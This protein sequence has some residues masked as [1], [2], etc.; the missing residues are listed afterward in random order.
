[1]TATTV[2]RTSHIGELGRF[3]H[4]RLPDGTELYFDPSTHRYFGEVKENAKANGGYSYVQASSLVGCSTPSKQLDTDP[5]PLMGWAA[6]LDQTGVAQLAAAALEA[7]EPL[8][9]LCTQRGIAEALWQSELTWRHV[10]DRMAT[11]GT[12]IHERIFLALATGKRPPSLSALSSTERAYGQAAIKWWRA[13]DP[14][15]LFAEHLTAHPELRVAGRFDLLCEIGGE[16]VLVDAKTREKGQARR[17]D[18]V[19][20]A[21]YEL[22]NEA[23][24][25][26]TSDRQAILILKPDGTPVEKRSKAEPA[27]FLAALGAY[28]AGQE[29]GKRMAK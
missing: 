17:S 7:D 3:A 16:R 5:E 21:G 29:L 4:H 6:K 25:I 23:C 2:A 27:D 13:N 10:R 12:N 19:Q 20:L 15:P 14:V 11:R 24:G 28:R 1:M 22:C 9:W 8:D 18:H 26:G